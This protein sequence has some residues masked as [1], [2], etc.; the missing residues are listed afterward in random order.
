MHQTMMTED[1]RDAVADLAGRTAA[2]AQTLQNATEVPCASTSESMHVTAKKSADCP[3]GLPSGLLSPTWEDVVGDLAIVS[4]WL[5]KVAARTNDIRAPWAQKLIKRSE[6]SEDFVI[7]EIAR[8][9]FDFAYQLGSYTCRDLELYSAE[10]NFLIYDMWDDPQDESPLSFVA[11]GP[12]AIVI[13]MSEIRMAYSQK[14]AP[15]YMLT[16]RQLARL[17]RLSEEETET[18]LEAEGYGFQPYGEN[19]REIEEMT[20]GEYIFWCKQYFT[21]GINIFTWVPAQPGFIPERH[22]AAG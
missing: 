10:I 14:D 16:T 20:T 3:D 8:M 17:V 21:H 19:M 1:T 5:Q 2:Q 4:F 9:A 7:H 6:S 12:F 18:L 22:V 13:E 15:N 11:P